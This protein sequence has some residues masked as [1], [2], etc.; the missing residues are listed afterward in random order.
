MYFRNFPKVDYV[1]TNGGIPVK[2]T[3]ITRMVKFLNH[4]T[5]SYVAF[6]FY[7]IRDGDTPE[8]IASRL[9]GDPNMHW[10]ILLTNNITDLYTDWPMTVN[11]F[12]DYVK[13][14][15]DD[16]DG[17]HHYEYTQESGDSK[18][19]I[20]LP[21]ESATTI[22]AGATAITNFEYEEAIQTQKRR[23]RVIQPMFVSEI[24]K[25][26]KLKLGVK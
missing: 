10:I 17:I 6:D 12:E 15:Y 1:H 20:E 13:S 4:T 2:M 26:L 18:F 16:V 7:D 21:N 22:P 23:I 11:R 9:Y 25:Q 24:K 14:K 5:T 19:T 8:S 3:D